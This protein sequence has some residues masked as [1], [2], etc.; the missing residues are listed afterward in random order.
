MCLRHLL[1]NKAETPFRPAHPSSLR[2]PVETLSATVRWLRISPRSQALDEMVPPCLP[3]LFNP[4][5]CDHLLS[6]KVRRTGPFQTP[7]PTSRCFVWLLVVLSATPAGG[8]V[9]LFVPPGGGGRD[10]ST[11]CKEP[12]K[13]RKA[14]H[15]GD[16]SHLG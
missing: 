3:L 4:L 7:L 1:R 13:K 5:R 2:L 12:K 15:C 9:C 14:R 6:S 8:L 16:N 10:P 11:C